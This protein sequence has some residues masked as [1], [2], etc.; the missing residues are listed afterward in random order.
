MDI[1]LFASAA[2]PQWWTRLYKSLQ[3]NKCEWEIVFVGPNEPKFKLPINFRYYQC[4]FKPTQ[5][6]QAAALRCVGDLIGWIADDAC[7]DMS[8]LDKVWLSYTWSRNT[9][10][11]NNDNRIIFTQST[12]ENDKD[13]S[14]EHHFFRH[15]NSTP[16]MA[17]MAFMKRDWFNKLGG[18]DR[19]FISGQA[20]NDIVMRAFQ[21]NGVI[22]SVPKSKVY[23]NHEEVHGGFLNK[24]KYRLGKNSFRTGYYNDRR[25][26][27]ECWVKEGYGTY[28]EN[29]LKHGTI[30]KER[31]LPFHSFNNENIL[32]VPCGPQGRWSKNA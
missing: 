21:D 24:I 5:C 15:D 4:D 12:I 13:V 1:S 9:P 11:L 17:P 8:S 10:Q 25:Y 7:Y 31:L 32:E 16:T 29:T 26:L 2:R 18:Y 3:G 19:N 30:S 6:Y 14:K 20:E 22:R 28:D 27:E 23:L